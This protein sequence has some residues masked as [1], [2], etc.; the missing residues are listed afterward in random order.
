MLY[1]KKNAARYYIPRVG[2]MRRAP[3]PS[4]PHPHHSSRLVGGDDVRG[5]GR[6]GRKRFDDRGRDDDDDDG[7]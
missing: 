6:A 1:G 2:I 3:I 4:P 5:D 7:S